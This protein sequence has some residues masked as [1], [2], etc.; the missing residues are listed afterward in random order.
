MANYRKYPDRVIIDK[1]GT[2]VASTVS[3]AIYTQLVTPDAG[4]AIIDDDLDAVQAKLVAN[5]AR[6]GT[7]SG[8]LKQVS[9]TQALAATGAYTANDVV[10]EDECETSGGE[11]WAFEVVARVDGGY[12]YIT[13]AIA[14]TETESK[15]PRLTLYLF[16]TEPEGCNLVDNE[17]NTAPDCADTAGYQGKID[18]PAMESVGTTDSNTIATPSTVGN[19]PLAFKCASNADDLYGVLVTRDATTIT[20]G[21]DMTIALTIEQY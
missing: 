15:T 21:D 9:V 6:I 7:V 3:H 10:C 13:K 1:D 4:T 14:D 5:T 12:G 16:N 2:D 18:F 11:I 8:V 19:L 20:T 17:P